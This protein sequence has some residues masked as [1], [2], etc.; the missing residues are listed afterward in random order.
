MAHP[1]PGYDV[2]TP[3]GE[4]GRWMAGYHTGDDYSTHGKTGVQVF[5][6]RSGTVISVRGT[7]GASYGLHVIVEGRRR[8]IRVGYCHLSGLAVEL[9]QW[10]TVGHLLGYSGNSGRST[11]PHLHYEERRAPFFYGDDRRPRFNHRG[12][13]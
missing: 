12:A 3:Y 8:R 10:I 2:S 7:W 4:P 9:G 5:A 6:A 1:I 11:G 13:Q